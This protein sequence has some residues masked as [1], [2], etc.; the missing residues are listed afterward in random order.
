MRETK[1][2][3]QKGFAMIAALLAILILTAVG[4]LVFTVST[5]DIRIST[6]VTGEKKAFSAAEAGVSMLL[7]GFGPLT[8]SSSAVANVPV[9]PATDP[10]SLYTIGAPVASGAGWIPMAGYT[11]STGGPTPPMGQDTFDT[12]VTGTNARYNSTVRIELGMG[13]GPVPFGTTYQ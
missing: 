2:H 12:V 9:D 8:F 7:Q 3:D 1:M 6:R 5:R 13:F 11:M 10:D 4:V